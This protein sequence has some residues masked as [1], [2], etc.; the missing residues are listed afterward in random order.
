[1]GNLYPTETE[2]SLAVDVAMKPLSWAI[3]SPEE[4]LKAVEV[5]ESSGRA[6]RV[7]KCTRGVPACIREDKRSAHTAGGDPG[8]QTLG[9]YDLL[10]L[11]A[12]DFAAEGMDLDQ[13]KFEEEW[14]KEGF[15][16]F[17]LTIAGAYISQW[18]LASM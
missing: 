9:D 11:A 13:S 1:M 8:N 7:C 6:D 15:P 16:A 18:Q 2:R 5:G 14:L 4:H 12:L 17:G 10:L 3:W